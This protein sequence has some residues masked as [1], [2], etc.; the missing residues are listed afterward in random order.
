MKFKTK[1]IIKKVALVLAGITA[2]T[3]MV[4][5]TKA[6]YDRLK[7]DLKTITPT[8]E[9]G[10]LGSDGKFVDDKSTLYTK[11]AFEAEGLQIKLDFDN[12]INYQIF[13]Y[14]DLDNFI[15]STAVL[16]S[17]Y[18]DPVHDG[19]ARIVIMPTDDEDEKISLVER[20]TYPGQ[21]T[22]QVNKKQDVQ[23]LN[24]LGRR[25]K[26][27]SSISSCRFYYGSVS[28]NNG[29]FSFDEDSNGNKYTVTSCDLL[30]V[31]R[32][33]NI[34]SLYDNG[35]IVGKFVVYG[36]KNTANG[37]VCIEDSSAV[38][39]YTL[40]N[41]CDYVVLRFFLDSKTEAGT[42][43]VIEDSFLPLINKYIKVSV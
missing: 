26:V 2:V 35:D 8:F 30:S 32:G 11:S 3:A 1:S 5:A 31:K 19:Y 42:Y 41:E 24:V 17:A 29:V 36:F 7:D 16:S 39:S 25:L 34:T 38:T 15:E 18:S 40:S 12:Q 21:M 37:L 4:F 23:Y 28:E 10:N 33:S 6:I 27:V 13:Y 14:D 20:V 43:S 9:V 22:I